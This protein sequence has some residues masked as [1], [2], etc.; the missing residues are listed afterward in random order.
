[1]DVVLPH[2]CLFPQ[3]LVGRRNR[4]LLE[5]G[6]LEASIRIAILV[7]PAGGEKGGVGRLCQLTSVSGVL[8]K[9]VGGW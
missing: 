2:G 5:G 1:M 7:D 9:M 6:R 8:T 3:L 4:R